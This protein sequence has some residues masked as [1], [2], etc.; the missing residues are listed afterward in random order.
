MA[1]QLTFDTFGASG[2]S[3]ALPS[4]FHEARRVEPV[5]SYEQAQFDQI[6]PDTEPPSGVPREGLILP[7]GVGL[8]LFDATGDGLGFDWMQWGETADPSRSR[9]GLDATVSVADLSNGTRSTRKLARQRCVIPL[10]R[11]SVPVRDGDVWSHLWV[12]PAPGQFACA[13]GIWVAEPGERARFAMVTG[14]TYPNRPML[15]SESDLLSWLRAP[16][17]D[18]IARI[19]RY[20]SPQ[21]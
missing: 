18:A 4:L 19:T 14:G 8:V 9:Q 13:A 17:K 16:L 12:S 2:A 21:P 1:Q 10:T 5:L 3:I 6:I 20:V 7:G 15:L 11:Y